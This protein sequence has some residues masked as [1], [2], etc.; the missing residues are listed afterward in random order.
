MTEVSTDFRIEN[1]SHGEVMV[2]ADKLW[3]AQTQRSITY[4]SIGVDLMPPEMIDAYAILKKACAS[5]TR[6]TVGCPRRRR[7]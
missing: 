2:P 6:R 3:G 1:D 7:T 4:F 5:S